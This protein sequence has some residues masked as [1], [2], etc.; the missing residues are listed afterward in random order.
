ME[1]LRQGGTIIDLSTARRTKIE[2]IYREHEARLLRFLRLRLGS[3]AEARDAAQETF[4]RLWKCGG[5]L[6]ADNIPALLFVTARNVAI[7][8]LRKTNRAGRSG[9]YTASSD[10][11]NDNVHDDQAGPDR[12]LA[13]KSDLALVVRIL[14]ELPQKC[15][16]AFIRYRFE[17][18][19]YEDIAQEMG[20]SQSMVRKYVLKAVSHCAARFEELEGWE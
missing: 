12:I 8:M 19:D 4:V 20:V 11:S 16:Y 13:A 3:D 18:R 7:D 1:S 9:F 10:E 15:R 17:D 2:I 6:H 14:E 5:Q